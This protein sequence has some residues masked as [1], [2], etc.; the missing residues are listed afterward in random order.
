MRRIV[1][2]AVV[3]AV[4]LLFFVLPS[5]ATVYTDWLWFLEMGHE[6]V[7]LRTLNARI[8]LG[9]VA[10]AVVFAVLFVNIRLAQ[11]GLRQRSFTVFGPQGPRTIAIDMRAAA[12]AC[13]ISAPRSWRCS[14]RSMRRLAGILAAWPATPCRSARVDPILGRDVSFYLFQLPLPSLPP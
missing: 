5:F 14:W 4:I 1:V 12:A 8:A 2:A 9:A 11:G 7:F 10:F 13:S 3:A 6:Q